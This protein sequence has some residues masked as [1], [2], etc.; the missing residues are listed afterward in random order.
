MFAV[1]LDEM[2]RTKGAHGGGRIGLNAW[3]RQQRE[4]FTAK[5]AFRAYLDAG[6]GGAGYMR[7][8]QLVA[9][10]D[11]REAKA[12]LGKMD[13][14]FRTT[15]RNM[16]ADG[17]VVKVSEAN[18]AAGTAALFSAPNARPGKGPATP[19]GT[20]QARSAFAGN[21]T[22]RRGSP[23]HTSNEPKN[24]A[25]GSLYTRA[26]ALKGATAPS[27][28]FGD[29]E[30]TGSALIPFGSQEPEAGSDDA[31]DDWAERERAA[32][33]ALGQDIPEPPPFDDEPETG[34]TGALPD[35]GEP[36]DDDDDDVNF[37]PDPDD[38]AY[39]DL[40]ALEEAGIPPSD[41]IWDLIARAENRTKA[42]ETIADDRRLNRR[43]NYQK[44]AVRVARSIFAN[45][46]KDW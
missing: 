44:W 1:G 45:L 3:V 26:S 9:A 8:Q 15:L 31:G 19:L 17:D 30:D 36:D 40:Q 21:L 7:Y 4:P 22:G 11:E 33:D 2:A 12:L 37:L 35:D 24:P 41:D 10:G 16:V 13:T 43:P 39:E 42:V 18:P 38:P 32:A 28:D 29:D 27:Q 5:A 46:G 20:K 23:G 14:G 25:A 6:G 34:E